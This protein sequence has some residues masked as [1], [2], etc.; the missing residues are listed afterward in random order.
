[1]MRNRVPSVVVRALGR[2]A[3]ARQLAPLSAEKARDGA[4]VLMST[5]TTK[6]VTAVTVG[7]GEVTMP[8]CARRGTQPFSA[9]DTPRVEEK[10]TG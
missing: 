3:T 10:N 7:L 8:P 5:P 6:A 2:G 4:P 1:M 9:Q